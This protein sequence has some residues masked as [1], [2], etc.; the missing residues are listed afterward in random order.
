M[1]HNCKCFIDSILRP[2]DFAKDL[3]I[4]IDLRDFV[5]DTHRHED[6]IPLCKCNPKHYEDFDKDIGKN[7]DKDIGKDKRTNG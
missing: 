2:K 3:A 6:H 4:P 1:Q 5:C 7:F